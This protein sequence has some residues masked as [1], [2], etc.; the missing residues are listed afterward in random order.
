MTA[1]AWREVVALDDQGQ[2]VTIGPVHTDVSVDK[3]RLEVDAYGWTVTGTAL[4]LSAQQF[5][6]LRQ[7]GDGKAEAQ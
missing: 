5:R 1:G 6:A 2:M 7:R 3:L 4:H